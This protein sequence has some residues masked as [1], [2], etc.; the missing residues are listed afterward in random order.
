ME[1][2]VYFWKKHGRYVAFTFLV[3]SSANYT[4]ANEVNTECL[5]TRIFIA[6]EN[7]KRL[8]QWRINI[9]MSFNQFIYKLPTDAASCLKM[10]CQ[11][12]RE[13]RRKRKNRANPHIS[14]HELPVSR[15]RNYTGEISQNAARRKCTK[16]ANQNASYNL[17]DAV[18][19]IFESAPYCIMHKLAY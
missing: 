2:S 18:Y 9:L 3:N 7:S 1:N 6:T 13:A 11:I 5:N 8:L 14:T 16:Y 4:R 19:M 10:G 15:N 17:Q 12:P